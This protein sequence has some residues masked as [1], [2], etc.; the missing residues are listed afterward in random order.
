MKRI[1]KITW[2]VACITAAFL[3]IFGATVGH[4]EESIQRADLGTS[5][6]TATVDQTKAVEDF[7]AELIKLNEGN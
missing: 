2:G 1:L 5:I 3:M 7:K 4:T 6:E